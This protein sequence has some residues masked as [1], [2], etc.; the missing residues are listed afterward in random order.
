MDFHVK[1]FCLDKKEDR[2]EYERI[3]KDG[4]VAKREFHAWDYK[5]KFYVVLEWWKNG[6]SSSVEE[7]DEDERPKPGVSRTRVKRGK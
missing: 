3:K 6:F 1:K 4:S 7:L 2:E 5:D